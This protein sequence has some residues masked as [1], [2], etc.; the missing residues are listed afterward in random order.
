MKRIVCL[1]GG[2]AGLYSAIL[3][4]KA[5]ASARVE[6]FERN[7]PDDTFGWGVVFSDETMESFREADRETHEAI[8]G[9]FDHWD[10]IE[11]HFAGRR[12]APAATASAASS[13]SA[14]STSCSSAPPSLGVRAALRARGRDATRR[15]RDADLI[16]AADGINS[17]IRAVARR[18]ASSRTSTCASAASSGSARTEISGLHLHLRAH[19]ARLVP[20]PRLPVQRR[21]LD[22]HR[23]DA[24]EHLAGARARRGSAPNSRSRSA[25]SSFARYLGGKPLLSN[26]RHLRGSA[27]LNFNR[28]LCNAL[29]STATSC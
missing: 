15:I 29:A 27:W 5:L 8:T 9:S 4:K 19:R 20:D 13:A 26:A 2:P 21:P 23:R 25:S 10:D 22:V 7:R 6:V 18:C 11:V 3:F 28:V 14:C 17:K 1:G 24:R 12:C 16:V